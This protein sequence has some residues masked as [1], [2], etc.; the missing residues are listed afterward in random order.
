MA[1]QSRLHEIL[2]EG[3]GYVIFVAIDSIIVNHW[4]AYK[5]VKARKQYNVPYPIMYVN[6]AKEGSDGYKF[7]CIQRA[8]QN[9]LELQP[10]FLT[11]LLLGGLQH[12]R[13]AVGA[14][15]IYT[16]GRI[17]YARGYHTG[18]PA[19]RR[20]GGFGMAGLVVLLGT[21]MCFAAH[22]LDWNLPS[23]LNFHK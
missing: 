13:V 7:N 11:F 19:K 15:I 2:P 17:V 10:A 22:Q 8:H 18:D 4:L 23:F 1:I 14:G 5:V 16:V 9:T 3:Y 6:D 12:P 21:T 20:H